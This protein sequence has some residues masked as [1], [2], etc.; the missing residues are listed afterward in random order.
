MSPKDTTNGIV[1]VNE[2]LLK[3]VLN[4]SWIWDVKFQLE[5]QTKHTFQLIQI[6]VDKTGNSNPLWNLWRPLNLHKKTQFRQY[7][8]DNLKK[9]TSA[10]LI[11][12]EYIHV[13]WS[14]I[15]WRK[16]KTVEM[17]LW[18]SAIKGMML[19]VSNMNRGWSEDRM[20]RWRSHVGI[21]NRCTGW[22]NCV[23]R[24]VTPGSK[25]L[26][27]EHNFSATWLK[28]LQW[29]SMRDYSGRVIFI[30]DRYHVLKC[31]LLTSNPLS[32]LNL[33]HL[34]NLLKCDL[35]TLQWR[36]ETFCQ[37]FC[38]MPAV[39]ELLEIYV[40]IDW[41]VKVTSRCCHLEDS[42]DSLRSSSIHDVGI[43]CKAWRSQSWWT[44]RS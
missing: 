25:D 28:P 16:P 15:S 35:P 12:T 40:C 41:G 7:I 3:A 17:L 20:T 44:A 39:V 37:V 1:S 13:I 24:I 29:G 31:L 30:K 34:M 33:Q 10:E 8:K 5:N 43:T 27:Q 6:H 19:S 11:H 32:F 18:V 36:S 22:A 23:S 38:H 26:K 42:R 14:N 2:H 21:R 4:S 9:K